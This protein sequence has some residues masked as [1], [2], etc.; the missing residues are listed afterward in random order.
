VFQA[1]VRMLLLAR[2]R[3]GNMMADMPVEVVWHI[4]DALLRLHLTSGSFLYS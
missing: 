2:Q 1:E 4:I 3:G